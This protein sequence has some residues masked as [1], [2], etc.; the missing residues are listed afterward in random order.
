[1]KKRFKFLMFIAI[2]SMNI[3]F[4]NEIQINLTLKEKEFLKKHKILKIPEINFPP[5]NF[6]KDGIVQGFSIDYINLITEKLNIKTKY[7][8]GYSWSEYL[9]MLSNGDIDILADISTSTER[10]KTLAFTDP[11]FTLY[12][13]FYIKKGSKEYNSLDE[14]DGKTY[15]TPKNYKNS[16]YIKKHYPLIKQ[17]Y[18]KSNLEA[19]QLLAQGKGDIVIDTKSVANYLLKTNN[20]TDIVP[21]NIIND[22]YLIDELRISVK[23][24]NTLLLSVLKKA[25]KNISNKEINRLK[26]KWF[27]KR[28]KKENL[29]SIQ[30]K[31]YLKNNTFTYA[32]DPNWLPFE[33]FDKQGKYIGIVSE[34]IEIIEKKLNIKFK[35]IITKDWINTLELSKKIK[36]DIISGDA[37]DVILAKNYKPIDTYIQNPLVLVTRKDHPFISELNHIKD[38]KIAYIDG[39]GYTADIV[40]KYPNIKFLKTNSINSALVGVKSGKYDIVIGTLSMIDYTIVS[41]GLEG[42]KI[43]GDTGIT[44]NLTLFINR[45]KPLLYSIINKTMNSIDDI[46]KHKIMSKW[47]H[48]KLGN[49]IDYTLIWQI[50][51]VFIFIFLIGLSFLII[52]RK[53]NKRLNK[54]LNSTIEAI[55]IFKNGKLIETNKQLLQMYGYS[56][57]ED[58]KGN[59]P[60]DFVSPSQHEFLKNQLKDSQKPYELNMVRSDGTNFPALVRGTNMDNNIRITS[61]LD[62]TELKD[63][64]K[65]F[66]LLNK[67]LEFKVKSEI[68]KNKQQQ[69]MMLQQSRLAQMGEIISMIAHQWRQP[70][71]SLAMINQTIILKY[72][73]DKLNDKAIEYFSKNSNKQIQGMSQTINDFRDFFKPEKEK[74]KFILNDIIQNTIDMVNPIFIKEKIDIILGV[75]NEFMIVGF[76]NELSQTILNIVNNA[77][78][79]LIENKIKDKQIV[80]SIKSKNKNTILT[81]SDNAGG[82]PLNV[83]DKIFNPYFSTKEAKKGTGLGL[84]MSKIIIE[85]H[86][87]GRITVA[88]SESGAVFTIILK[89]K[90]RDEK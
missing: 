39:Y 41:M 6:K 68:E 59:T 13:I 79:A 81:I 7:I 42:I 49:I 38:K 31:E 58:I 43:S 55:A 51:G 84:Y 72:H 80:I 17:L 47:R 44:M 14:L 12:N 60:L 76:P 88:N 10:E 71:N 90:E 18:V 45:E 73:R 50:I 9:T 24:T 64:Q 29:L 35:K 85:E 30:E 8:S 28:Y 48:T 27:D 40:K 5:F 3:L 23:K 1:M 37:A 82:I 83:I 16:N 53:N 89:K 87:G 56:S 63:T 67:S 66:E 21:S 62:L 78:D 46:T 65:E 19:F 32:G 54:L 52:S 70:L 4:A 26:E 33:A 61:V 75:D 86:M 20:I 25:Q 69:L 34:H 74:V 22:R 11:Y 36:S 15:I 77:K 2:L 57:I